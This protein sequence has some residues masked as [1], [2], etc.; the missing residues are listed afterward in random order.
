[1]AVKTNPRVKL[2]LTVA[3]TSLWRQT[4]TRQSDNKRRCHI[5]ISSGKE[6][7]L[8]HLTCQGYL[9][10]RDK[11]EKV[12]PACDK[13]NTAYPKMCL[14]LS[15]M[16]P[17]SVKHEKMRITSWMRRMTQLCFCRI[18]ERKW[19]WRG[20]TKGKHEMRNGPSIVKR[21]QCW[22]KHRNM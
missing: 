19:V 11:T 13:Y 7:L 3:L 1:M 4:K 21:K 5:A 16:K 12:Q 20:R 17:L 6:L 14:L 10:T 9:V 8:L 2:Q 22:S 15:I 18:G